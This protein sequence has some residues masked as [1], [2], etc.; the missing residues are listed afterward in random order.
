MWR[1]SCSR[2]ALPALLLLLVLLPRK[3]FRRLRT[4]F[5]PATQRTRL[6][7]LK[8]IHHQRSLNFTPG[9]LQR[10]FISRN[11]EVTATG[12]SAPPL[13]RPEELE[14][15]LKVTIPTDL[16]LTIHLLLH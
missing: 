8:K 3:H 6:D 5:P 2:R 16:T 14:L 9:R 1:C 10:H 13:L 12:P 15:L 4:V 11:M 7:I